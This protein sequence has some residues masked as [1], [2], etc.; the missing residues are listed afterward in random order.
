MS[1]FDIEFAA[2]TDIGK[3]REKNEDS[4]LISS[5]LGLGV[6]A[7]GMGGHSAGEIASNIAVH[8]LEETIR[9]VNTG[10]L[11]MP[12]TFLPKLDNTERKMLMAANLANA[13]I[14]TTAQASEIYK[15]MGTTLTGVMFDGDNAT[16]VH[17]GDSRIYLFRDGKL[18]Q[19]T[20]DHSLAMEHVRRGLL[21]KAE[22]DKSKIQNVLTRA[23][24]IKK[25]VEFDLLRFPVK[26]GDVMVLCSDGLY[27]GMNETQL[28]EQLEQGKNLPLVKLCKQLVR[29]SNDNDGQDNISAVMIKIL[30]P[31]RLSFKQ[32]VRR[33][34]GCY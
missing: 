24:G 34:F 9:K 13:A 31:Q 11:K 6:V 33:F 15:M 30:P 18:V 19:V 25:N 23:M 32:K 14:Y 29:V 10:E 4:V 7:D 8:V 12:E 5:D 2:V 17:V 22:A 27:K 26:L 1:A 3:I 20:T 21:T 28:A 16:A